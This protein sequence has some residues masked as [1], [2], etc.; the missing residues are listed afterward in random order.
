MKTDQ[1][2][3]S[4]N[5]SDNGN[6][7]FLYFGLGWIIISGFVFQFIGNFDD[8]EFLGIYYSLN[9]VLWSVVPLAIASAIRNREIKMIFT[10]LSLIYLAINVIQLIGVKV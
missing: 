4:N 7:R 9:S 8:N 1:S 6:E 10:V 3:N 2:Q 5:Q